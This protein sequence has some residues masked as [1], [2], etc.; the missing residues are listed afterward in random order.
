[1]VQASHGMASLSMVSDPVEL[2]RII[3]SSLMENC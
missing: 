2:K 3:K 1:M